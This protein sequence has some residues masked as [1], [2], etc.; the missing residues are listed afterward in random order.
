MKPLLWLVLTLAVLV[1]AASSLAFTGTEQ[2]VISVV[3]GL[4]AIGTATGLY[5]TR[6]RHPA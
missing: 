5:L 1:N 3:T 4:I 2:A 6:D